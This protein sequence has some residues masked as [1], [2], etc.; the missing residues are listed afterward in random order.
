MRL[1]LRVLMR[2][3]EGRPATQYNFHKIMSRVW[4]VCMPVTIP[5]VLFAPAFWAK[6]G[7]LLVA[8]ISYYANFAT[9]SGAMAAA[10]ASTSENITAYAIEEAS[11][12]EGGGL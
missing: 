5:I 1:G 11:E 12:A 4:L 10:N 9:D 2:R 8:E 3:V 6:I 7:V